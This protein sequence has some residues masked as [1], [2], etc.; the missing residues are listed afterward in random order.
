MLMTA[1]SAPADY[2]VKSIS[3]TLLGYYGDGPQYDGGGTLTDP[4]LFAIANN[5]FLAGYDTTFDRF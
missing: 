2:V 5:S 3:Y 4:N 1:Y